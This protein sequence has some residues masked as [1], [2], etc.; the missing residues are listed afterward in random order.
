[1]SDPENEEC[2]Y[3]Y[4][5][6]VWRQTYLTDVT[7][8]NLVAVAVIDSLAV[9]PTILLNALVILAV[10]TRDQLRSRTK[11]N[12]LVACLAGADLLGGLVVQPIKIAV[13]LKRIFGDGPF[14]S[15]E[16]ALAV[17]SLGQ[18]SFSLGSLVLLS[19][20]RYI[21]IK[22][23][24]S[25]RTIVTTKRIKTGFVLVWGIG[26][27]VT[28]AELIS[29]VIDCGTELYLRFVKVISVIVIIL[30]LLYIAV[31]TYTYC[32]IFSETQRQKKRLQTE[33]QQMS[34]E[35]AKRLKKETK[36]SNTLTIILAGLL[37]TNMPSII[38][39]IAVTSSDSIVQPHYLSVLWSWIMTLGLF[40]NLFEPIIYFWRVKKLRRAILEILHY[41]QPEN[42][43]PPI[44]M[45]ERK[46]Y[47]PE[48]RPTT[49]EAFSMAIVR[50]E[51]VLI[52]YRHLEDEEIISIEESSV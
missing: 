40:S 13:E 38:L 1:M 22:H 6:S 26:L 37:I 20:E 14:C 29:A 32:Y 43:P 52:S 7:F 33:Q 15:L 4:D 19:I 25:Y 18:G 44:E 45:M 34:R 2:H 10:V 8:A 51:P 31:I 3:L 35:E 30:A 16:K 50:Q 42:S 24:L 46:H 49:C 12:I 47:R 9:L 23:S 28:F 17:A 11:S 27:L 21:S 36:A 5:G 41:R 48:V 39:G